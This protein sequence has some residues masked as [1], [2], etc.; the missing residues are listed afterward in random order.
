MKIKGQ[1]SRN[2]VIEVRRFTHHVVFIKNQVKT[3]TVITLEKL[4][5]KAIWVGKSVEALQKAVALMRK[6]E[7]K[8]YM[9]RENKYRKQMVLLFKRVELYNGNGYAN[10]CKCTWMLNCRFIFFSFQQKSYLIYSML[11]LKFLR[12]T[13]YFDHSALL[14]FSSLHHPL[15]SRGLILCGFW[16]WKITV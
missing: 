2:T 15:Q 11:P 4:K 7:G 8:T 13:L 9:N 5:N 10:W 16:I 3:F 12:N 14:L 1:G 6:M